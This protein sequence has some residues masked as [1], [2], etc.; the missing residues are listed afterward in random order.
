MRT[1]ASTYAILG[2]QYVRENISSFSECKYWSNIF[3]L[4]LKRSGGGRN[5]LVGWQDLIVNPS[6]DSEKGE[7][8][9]E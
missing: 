4:F 3:F 7:R 1:Y 9:R 8:K 2:Y 6:S 5:R